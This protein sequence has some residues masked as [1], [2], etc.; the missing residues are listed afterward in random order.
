MSWPTT[1]AEV[2]FDFAESLENLGAY[3]GEI[4]DLCWNPKGGDGHVFIKR[5]KCGDR[6]GVGQYPD[7]LA[8]CGCNGWGLR[9]CPGTTLVCECGEDESWRDHHYFLLARKQDDETFDR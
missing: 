9:P 7:R 8:D 4:G 1:C 5:V 3:E 6:F 2:T